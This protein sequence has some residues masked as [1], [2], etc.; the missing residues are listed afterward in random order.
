MKTPVGLDARLPLT[1][2]RAGACCHGNAV[3]LNPWELA[4]LAAATGLAPAEFAAR[5][6][7]DGGLRLAFDAP[8]RWRGLPACRLYGAEVGCTVH[9]ARPLACRLF[10]LARERRGE[11][12]AWTHAGDVLPCLASCPEVR[13]LPALSV[14]DYLAGQEV[15]PAVAAHDAYL[16][17]AQA[18]A[19]GAFVLLLD[20]G[21]AASGDRRTLRRW[22]ALGAAS[23]RST[24]R[25]I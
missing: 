2:S 15:G 25:R 5:Y 10:P 1:C 3:W 4:R 22:R 20:S 16:E 12:V 19:D 24:A 18:L 8:S 23:D 11:A 14:A 7:L 21:L 13:A 6:T 17:L 9:P